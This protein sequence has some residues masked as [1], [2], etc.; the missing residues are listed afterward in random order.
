MM[1]GGQEEERVN[2]GSSDDDGMELCN[3]LM[4][5]LNLPSH[6]VDIP[7]LAPLY[8]AGDSNAS[9]RFVP[10]APGSSHPD[11][12]VFE[13][14]TA[15]DVPP[16]V[17]LVGL[18]KHYHPNRSGSLAVG[19]NWLQLMDQDRYAQFRQDFDVHYSFASEDEWKLAHWLTSSGLPQSQ[20]N[21]FLKLD[22]LSN[23]SR[24]QL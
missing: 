18:E 6:Y 19:Q 4:V 10:F 11:L 8:D 3:C 21:N 2:D 17:S 23:M 13:P 9:N 20:I 7:S 16:D 14:P 15:A 22:H 12:P 1:Y 24:H 5:P